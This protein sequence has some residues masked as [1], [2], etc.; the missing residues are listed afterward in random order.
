MTTSHD[1]GWIDRRERQ[2]EVEAKTGVLYRAGNTFHGRA[3][4]RELRNRN[5]R[6]L[7]KKKGK[8]LSMHRPRKRAISQDRLDAKGTWS[9]ET[10]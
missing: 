8:A 4:R 5:T 3:E 2:E 9:D 10:W 7:R 1:E 6:L